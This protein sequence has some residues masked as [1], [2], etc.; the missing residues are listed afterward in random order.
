MTRA[1]EQ[2][3]RLADHMQ[4]T[5]AEIKN[6]LLSIGLIREIPEEAKPRIIPIKSISDQ[7]SNKKGKTLEPESKKKISN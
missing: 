5:G 3:F 2:T 1:F 6:G 7:E 4:V